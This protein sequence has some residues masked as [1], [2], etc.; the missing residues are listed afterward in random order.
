[1]I[2]RHWKG[3][4]KASHAA[5]YH[6]HLLNDTLKQLSAING[7]KELRILRRDISNGVAFLVITTWGNI[8]NIKDFAG[9]D[10][11]RA[12]VPPPVQEMMIAYDDRVIHYE[13]LT[14]PGNKPT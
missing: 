1:M 10:I 9:H 5:E 8:E 12:V 13:A 7:F 4:C 3:I 6:V 2:E 11:E 14:Y